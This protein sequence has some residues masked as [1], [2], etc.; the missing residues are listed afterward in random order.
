MGFYF[1][2]SLRSGPFRI[3]FSKSGVSYSFGAKGARINTGPRG[4]Y[5]TFGSHGI[6]YRKKIGEAGPQPVPGAHELPV[7][8]ERHT[9]TS[10]NI[11]TITDTDS[12]EFIQ[13]LIQKERKI[14]YYRWF[15]I[16]PLIVLLLAFF[17][18][19]L[20]PGEKRMLEVAGTK[21][22]VTPVHVS[23]ANIRLAPSKK[24]PVSGLLRDGEQA[25]LLDSS[26]ASWYKI[27]MGETQGFVS[28]SITGTVSVVSLHEEEDPATGRPLIVDH[29]GRFWTNLIL[30]AVIFSFL[31]PLLKRLD[32]KRMLVEI[33]YEI[34]EAVMGIYEK[35][36]EHF[37]AVFHCSKVW[38]Y[39]HSQR[40]NGYKYSGG[41]SNSIIR[42]QLTRMSTDRKPSRIFRTNVKIPY[43]GLANTE[44]FFFPERLIIKR[45]GHYGG[46][47]YR[48]IQCAAEVTRFIESESVPRDSEV[49]DHTWR[50]LNKDGGPDRRFNNNRRLPICLYSEYSFHSDSGLNERIATSKKHGLDEFVRHIEAIGHLQA[51]MNA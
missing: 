21:I 47:M 17:I 16:F 50:F 33:Y 18:V 39:L 11:E 34:D 30:I 6:Y 49:V 44:L 45:G 36:V 43:L 19:F 24:A 13:E 37:S 9:I 48:N 40:T 12:Q 35:F 29:P 51:L 25:E 5:V 2:K 26:N 23:S 42:T 10:G 28:R 1:R 38:Q 7:L 46:I 31:L 3:N 14:A 20:S 4:T 27:S 15:G 32:R 41:A 22:Y 8:H